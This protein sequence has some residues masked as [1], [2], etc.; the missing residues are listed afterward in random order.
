[1]KFLIVSTLDLF[2]GLALLEDY[3][4]WK[5]AT[6]VSAVGCRSPKEENE[7]RQKKEM[8][9]AK[10]WSAVQFKGNLRR[11]AILGCNLLLLLR[12]NLNE[13]NLLWLR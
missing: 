5:P 2:Y 9:E 4:R 12:I 6:V 1:L 10:T 8:E 11:D 13:R 3:K 7:R